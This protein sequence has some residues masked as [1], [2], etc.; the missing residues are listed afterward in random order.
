MRSSLEGLSPVMSDLESP[1]N[2]VF[3]VALCA[4]LYPD[5]ERRDVTHRALRAVERAVGTGNPDALILKGIQQA[6]CADMKTYLIEAQEKGSTH[7]LLYYFFGESCWSDHVPRRLR[8]P[9]SALS[10][11]NKA[12]EGTLDYLLFEV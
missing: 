11:Y 4:V 6:T 9:T 2:D 1:N 7:P 8:D 10:Y 12:I 5:G 3:N